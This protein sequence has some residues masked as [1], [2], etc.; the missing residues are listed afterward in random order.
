MKRSCVVVPVEDKRQVYRLIKWVDFGD[1]LYL[2]KNDDGSIVMMTMRNNYVWYGMRYTPDKKYE[3]CAS[4]TIWRPKY[5][6]SCQFITN[7]LGPRLEWMCVGLRSVSTMVKLNAKSPIFKLHT[8]GGWKDVDLY[9]YFQQIVEYFDLQEEDA[10]Y[11]KLTGTLINDVIYTFTALKVAK[12]CAEN[13]VPVYVEQVL[14]SSHPDSDI[15]SL[16]WKSVSAFA[17]FLSE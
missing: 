7:I 3:L 15:S 4:M 16:Y 1:K 2:T 11:H 17:K 6:E 9:P 5:Y 12:D 13:N 10:E 14:K 8:E